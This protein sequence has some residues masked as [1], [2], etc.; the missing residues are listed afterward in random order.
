VPAPLKEEMRFGILY[1]RLIR[2]QFIPTTK[3]AIVPM[4]KLSLRN[5][6]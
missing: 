1:P 2:S 4:I 6:S 3:S 5:K